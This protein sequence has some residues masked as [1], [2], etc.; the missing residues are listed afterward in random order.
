MLGPMRGCI[1]HAVACSQRR[2][3][4]DK[5]TIDIPTNQAKIA[6]MV[7]QLYTSRLLVYYAA[8]LLDQHKE[9]MIEAANAKMLVSDTYEKIISDAIKVLGGDGGE[10]FYQLKTYYPDHK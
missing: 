8:H 6:E 3:Q 2:M 4:F 10:R 9:A 1:R 5:P 7:S